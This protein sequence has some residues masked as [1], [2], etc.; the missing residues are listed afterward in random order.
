MAT[1]CMPRLHSTA[2]LHV[3]EIRLVSS[4]V[5]R[6]SHAWCAGTVTNVK[7]ASLWLSYTYLFVRMLRNPLH[8]G[9]RWEEISADPRLEGHRIKLITDAAREL[10]RCKMAR[11]DENSRN[12]YVTELGRVASH[13]YIRHSS[14]VT[15]NDLLTS[16]MGEADVRIPA[17]VVPEAEAA[18]MFDDLL[19]SHSAMGKADIPVILSVAPHESSQHLCIAQHVF[20]NISACNLSLFPPNLSPAGDITALLPHVTSCSL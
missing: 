1:T 17:F 20:P 15:F 13:F 3:H 18:V 19:I 16:H 12:L 5:W 11:F 2:S 9:I 8:Y 7:E 4:G 6:L 14:I 10:E